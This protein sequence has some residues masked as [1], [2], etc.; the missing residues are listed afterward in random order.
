VRKKGRVEIP[1][2][3]LAVRREVALPLQVPSTEDE[4]LVGERCREQD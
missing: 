3:E 2:K 1:R 4:H